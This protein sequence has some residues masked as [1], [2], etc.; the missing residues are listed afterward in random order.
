M[1]SRT[2]AAKS[3]TVGTKQKTKSPST[4]NQDFK[5][6]IMTLSDLQRDEPEMTP[7]HQTKKA[8]KKGSKPPG[9][10]SFGKK[11]G[12]KG[13]G[14]KKGPVMI[15][16]SHDSDKWKCQ[17]CSFMNEEWEDICRRCE[18]ERGETKHRENEDEGEGE[19]EEN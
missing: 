9:E 19:G 13:P 12:M 6:R 8:S 3:R 5:G 16:Q 1:N 17:I 7:N 4:Q 2:F 10:K 15:G 11:P 18:S 14:D